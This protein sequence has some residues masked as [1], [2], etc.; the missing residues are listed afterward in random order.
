MLMY[1][2]EYEVPYQLDKSKVHRKRFPL[3]SDRARAA[4]ECDTLRRLYGIRASVLEVD[5]KETR[6]IPVGRAWYNL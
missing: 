6:I 5:A 2:C 3:V 1:A 4:Y